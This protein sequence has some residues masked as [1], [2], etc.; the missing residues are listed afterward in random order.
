[1]ANKIEDRLQ[2]EI[3][4][5]FNNEFCLKFHNPRY[6]IFSVP[7]GGNRNK[8]EAMTFKATGLLS[9]VSDLIVVLPNKV[10]FVELK[11]EDL[12]KSNQS[13]EQKDFQKRV[14]ELGFEYKLIRTLNEFK[15]WLKNK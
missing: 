4:K 12:Q 3:V 9:G 6:L 1:M 11:T 10:Y 8:I 15:E 2:A 7:N 5:W 14:E 13:E